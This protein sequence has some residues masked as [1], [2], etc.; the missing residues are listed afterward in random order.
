MVNTEHFRRHWRT[1][2]PRAEEC[3]NTLD[4][5]HQDLRASAS[6]IHDATSAL[7]QNRLAAE[8]AL[9]QARSE[10]AQHGGPSTVEEAVAGQVAEVA[11]ARRR[12]DASRRAGEA[13]GPS[14]A[15]VGNLLKSGL[16]LERERI[17]AQAGG[18][19]V[20]FKSDEAP[21]VKIP[22]GTTLDSSREEIAAYSEDI[23]K[24][25]AAPPSM[26]EALASALA[27]VPHVDE[28]L[29]RVRVGADGVKVNLPRETVRAESLTPGWRPTVFDAQPMFHHLLGDE[30]RRQVEEQVRAAYE[31]I[32]FSVSAA[33]RRRV[34][35]EL[36]A[37]LLKAERIECELIW[38]ARERGEDILWRR[39]TDP[40]A[41]IGLSGPPLRKR[42][43]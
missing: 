26:D 1:E 6:G 13:K 22:K 34:L 12:E 35:A 32:D 18:A 24:L 5:I 9:A 39:G 41:L 15:L 17:A 33:D 14:A 27:Q 3:L 21:P 19:D 40:R 36:R 8:G 43:D 28:P 30:V 7:Y 23:D 11:E 37:G 10:H 31:D 25:L 4:E 29:V 42:D 20:V 2:N 16:Q 38:Q